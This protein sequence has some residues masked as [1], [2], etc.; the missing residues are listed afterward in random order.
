[1]SDLF[2]SCARLAIRRGGGDNERRSTAAYFIHQAVADLFGKRPDRGY[3]YR[4]TAE[5]EEQGKYEV[6]ILSEDEPLPLGELPSPS[7]RRAE[8]IKSKPFVPQLVSGQL[9]DFEI[10]INATRVVTQPDGKKQRKDI[11]EAV[12]QPDKE[13]PHTPHHVYG[14]YLARKLVGAAELL[15]QQGHPGEGEPSLARVTERGEVRARRGDR[16]DAA[17]FVA[18]NLIGTLHV[19]DPTRFLEIVATG[20]GRAKG[21]GCGFLCISRPGT[22]LARRYPERAGALL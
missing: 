13:T 17:R 15:P 9:L 8:W 4:V 2:L 14:E 10:R 18:T 20:V 19:Q 21:F 1:M 7:H 3:L 16:A 22:V 12:W 11:W 6:L 5:R